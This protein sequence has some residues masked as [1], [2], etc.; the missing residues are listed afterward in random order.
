[1]ILQPEIIP[2]DSKDG[3]EA[4]PL[5]NKFYKYFII[6]IGSLVALIILKLA[7]QSILIFL[8]LRFIW[9]IAIS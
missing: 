7:I 1:M 4:K 2:V 9:K 3:Y 8:G 5:Q 6:I